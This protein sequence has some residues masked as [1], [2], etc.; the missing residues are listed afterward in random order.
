MG[1]PLVVAVSAT[2]DGKQAPMLR[3]ATTS[4]MNLDSDV[5]LF[6]IGGNLTK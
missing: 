5:R 6:E 3:A 1:P 4:S 2:T